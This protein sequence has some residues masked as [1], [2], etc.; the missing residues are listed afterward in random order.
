MFNN[1]L[2]KENLKF[3][4]PSG[5]VVFLVALPLCLGISLASG[6][7]LFSG[8]LTG[9]VGGIVVGFLSGSQL[10]V[11]GPAAGLTVIVFTAINDLNSYSV[12]LLAVVLAGLIQVVFGLIRAGSLSNFFP[13]N[14]IDGM[15]AAIGVI[16][17]LK[18]LPHAVGYD[19]DYEG[20]LNFAQDGGENTF[21]T[22]AH[23]MNSL[24]MGALV[25]SIASI[26]ILI[27]W[28]KLKKLQQVPGALI[29]VAVGVLFNVFTDGTSL[30]IQQEHLVQIP[31]VSSGEDFINLFSFPDWSA[32]TNSKVW[33]VALTI[34][35]VAS[36]ETLLCIE[37][38]DKLD[39]QRRTSPANR[40]LFAQGV[41]N[42]VAGAIG[43]IPMTSV[44]VRSSANVNSGARTKVSA[45]V[46]GI[47][48]FSSILIIP[49][50]L[51]LIPLASLAA[52]LIVI[53]Y[54]LTS[55]SLIKKLLSQGVE[56]YVPFVITVLAIVFTDLLKGVG[57]GMVVALIFILR[58]TL[59][60]PFSFTKKEDK[61][62]HE[63]RLELAE[64]LNFLNKA[65]VKTA[66]EKVPND[67]KVIIDGS[68][69]HYIDW[70]VLDL[71]EKFRLQAKH[72]NIQV[73]VVNV[74]DKYEL[75][76][77]DY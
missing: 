34:A 60:S 25:L 44:I 76:K 20:D 24:S 62:D 16:L 50:V 10:S 17:I 56:R 61:Q 71:I 9:V 64:V 67:S 23:A 63:I 3:D 2:N 49:K 69:T 14:V 72:K 15:L 21:S 75:P 42:M 37:A 26:L 77:I 35:L 59:R 30:G 22:I 58:N 5:L 70:D 38:V 29:V 39:P 43:G 53:G 66:L 1:Y 31:V 57:I 47:L 40:E 68:K 11:S 54:K 36:I 19:K 13:S 73:E 27:Y 65:S 52:I 55:I 8:I 18:Q 46:H 33:T 4:L 45:I 48:L 6:A 32:F 12:F 74:K 51:N 7:P 41:G 28:P